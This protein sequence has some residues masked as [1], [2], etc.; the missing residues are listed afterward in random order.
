MQALNVLTVS[1]SD[2]KMSPGKIFRMA[3]STNNGVYVFNRGTVVGVML[4]QEQYERLT[5]GIEALTDRLIETEAAKRLL[6]A[7]QKIYKDHEV[8]DIKSDDAL[9]IDMDD[10]WN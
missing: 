7:A 4:T 5:D 3:E 1:I 8:R 9:P 2:V 6:I 10:G